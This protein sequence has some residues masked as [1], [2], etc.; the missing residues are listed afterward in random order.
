MSSALSIRVAIQDTI[1]CPKVRS[2]HRIK[3]YADGEKET[4][5]QEHKAVPKKDDLLQIT[6]IHPFEHI[7][8]AM[9]FVEASY[10]A[11][12]VKRL[13]TPARRG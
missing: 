8:C 3:G 5:V 9:Y 2:E 11:G 13:D 10:G 1:R 12:E 4:N 7:A 6:R